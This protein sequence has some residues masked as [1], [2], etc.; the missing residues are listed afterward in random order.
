MSQQN[1]NTKK[2]A[3]SVFYHK[4]SQHPVNGKNIK[5]NSEM[6]QAARMFFSLFFNI[7][8]KFFSIAV[9]QENKFKA[10]NFDN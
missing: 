1:K 10:T 8:I 2:L 4:P 9:R 3:K 5:G 6:R 7:V